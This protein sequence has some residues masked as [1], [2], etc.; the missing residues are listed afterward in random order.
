[1]VWKTVRI[2]RA[3]QKYITYNTRSLAPDLTTVRSK[4]E[5]EQG[6]PQTKSSGS[7][8]EIHVEQTRTLGSKEVEALMAERKGLERLEWTGRADMAGMR[9]EQRI[10]MATA[11]MGPLGMGP[12]GTETLDMEPLEPLGKAID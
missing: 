1:M 3:P 9:T 10:G 2:R 11:C 5:A 8:S 7:A 4:H 12:R 6:C